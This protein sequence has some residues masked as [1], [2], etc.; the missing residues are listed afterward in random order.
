MQVFV[1][2]FG[3]LPRVFFRLLW[4]W[5]LGPGI[6]AYEPAPLGNKLS[7]SKR[8][9]R[10]ETYQES[11][12]IR[13]VSVLSKYAHFGPITRTMQLLLHLLDGH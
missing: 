1:I 6:W 5:I 4:A 3:C 8:L 7:T 9:C 11:W 2:S 12:M 13:N 10:V